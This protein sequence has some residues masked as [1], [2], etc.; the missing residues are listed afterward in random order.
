M[1]NRQAVRTPK[2]KLCA[3]DLNRE[4]RVKDR[5]MGAP[6]F[7]EDTG[8]IDTDF[9]ENFGVDQDLTIW[10]GIKT[11]TGKTIFDGV[12]TDPTTL[13]HEVLCYFDDRI[14]SQSWLLTD[15]GRLLDIIKVEDFDEQGRYS[16]LLCRER[17]LGKAAQA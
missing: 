13:T 16:R 1:A 5:Q 10:A 17:G 4:I 8:M 7:D 2:R 14:T 15:D 3:G 9:T 12:S 11:L 6:I